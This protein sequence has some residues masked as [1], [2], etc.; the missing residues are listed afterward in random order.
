MSTANFV[1]QRTN[2]SVSVAEFC[3]QAIFLSLLGLVVFTAVPYGTVE[4]WW[5]AAFVCAVF[6]L[7][8]PAIIERL[9][10]GAGRI[11]GMALLVPML[12]LVAFALLQTVPMIRHS[13]SG[14]IPISADAYGTQF[15]AL[16]LLA[17]TLAAAL[18]YRYVST[19]R[20]VRILIHVIIAVAAAS[21]IYG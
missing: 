10:S 18:L 16:Q 1:D 21:A 11:R 9:A 7:C 2:Q 20:R 8:V 5:K 12:A 17:L 13:N 14:W 6:A 4:P 3:S 15:F 19:E